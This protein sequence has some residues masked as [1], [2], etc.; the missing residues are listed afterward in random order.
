MSTSPLQNFNIKSFWQK[1]EGKAG[2]IFLAS[3]GSF[4]VYEFFANIQ[5]IVS[6][7]ENTI[8]LG[9]MLGGLFV[10]Y[11]L[12]SSKSFRAGMSNLFQ[13]TMRLFTGMVIEID[14][15]GILQNTVDKMKDSFAKLSKA[16]EGC[17]GAKK[18]VENQINTNNDSIR[19]A[20]SLKEQAEKMIAKTTDAYQIQHFQLERSRQLQEIGRKIN[21]NDKL[22]KILGQTTKLYNMLIRFQDLAQF[23]I[24]NTTSE[25]TNAK[26]E[27]KTILAAFKGMSFARKLISG[28]DEQM[29]MFNASLEYLAEDNAAKLGAMEDFA[30]YSEH[31]LT[32][33]DLQQGAAA[34]DAE[35]MLA[36]Y[37]QRLLTVGSSNTV[38]Q[39]V[40]RTAEA[41]PVSRST[42][43]VSGD[44]LDS[45]K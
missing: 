27:R 24:E 3:L 38:P 45:L 13:S 15:I 12:L 11:I 42:N 37:E 43:A 20:T 1:P 44:Y 5:T 4:A 22:N 23:N 34:D 19:K 29:K 7:V 28:D 40:I 6:M 9:F 39:G 36:Q 32:N 10:V 33:M 35:K 17:S 30:R 21:S 25:V 8:Y 41:V 18:A 16:I 2:L 14:P 26:E 31:Y